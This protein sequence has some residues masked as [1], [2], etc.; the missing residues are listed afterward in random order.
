MWRH[1]RN[2]EVLQ[3]CATSGKTS[4]ISL[5][6][7][8]QYLHPNGEH[9]GKN[10]LGLRENFP[11]QGEGPNTSAGLGTTERREDIYHIDI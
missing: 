10:V 11:Q 3:P 9:N 8:L 7:S 1:I 6:V 2:A 4:A 5:K